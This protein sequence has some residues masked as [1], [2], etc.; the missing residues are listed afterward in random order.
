MKNLFIFLIK[1]QMCILHS[2]LGRPYIDT[3]KGVVKLRG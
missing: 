3:T 2:T 1:I